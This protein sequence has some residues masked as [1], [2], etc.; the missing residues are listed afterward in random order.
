MMR[1]R[2]MSSDC[3]LPI[4]KEEQCHERGGGKRSPHSERRNLVGSLGK[5]AQLEAREINSIPT[6][7]DKT[8][9]QLHNPI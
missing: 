2:V 4:A 1:V 6:D 9:G 3:N 7:I 8:L 5:F